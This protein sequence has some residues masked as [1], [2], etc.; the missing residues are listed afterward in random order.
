[1]QIIWGE[2]VAGGETPKCRVPLWRVGGHCREGRCDYSQEAR[3][4]RWFQG[5]SRLGSSPRGVA[6]LSQ[7][8]SRGL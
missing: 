5:D 6:V 3:K 2:N 1:M 7:E 4:R 8:A